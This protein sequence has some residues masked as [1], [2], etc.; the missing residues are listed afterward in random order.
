GTKKWAKEFEGTGVGVP[1]IADDGTI[2]VMVYKE[3]HSEKCGWWYHCLHAVDSNNPKEEKWQSCSAF[4][5]GVP[6]ISSAGNVY[7]LRTYASFDVWKT[8]IYGFDPQRDS[9]S[10]ES[11]GTIG[12][13]ILDKEKTI[14]ALFDNNVGAFD[15]QLKL[16]W[17]VSLNDREG[18]LSLGGDGALF[19]P[20]E[21]KLYMIRPR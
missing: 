1:S 3:E 21:K 11:Y 9:W 15:Q 14:Y 18:P 17:S 13:L 6:V 10:S 2:Y 8:Q 20:G 5:G 7:I 12:H 19:V 4:Y 16:K